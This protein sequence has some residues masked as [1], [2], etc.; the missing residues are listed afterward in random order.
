LKMNDYDFSIQV[1]VQGFL[2]QSWLSCSV[3]GS[4][5]LA[6]NTLD[7]REKNSH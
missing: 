6:S 7:L 5:K 2:L 4:W 3:E 1:F